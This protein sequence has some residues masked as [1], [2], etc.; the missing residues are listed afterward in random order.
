MKPKWLF[1]QNRIFIPKKYKSLCLV[2]IF[3]HIQ[4]FPQKWSKY[5]RLKNFFLAKLDICAILRNY[6]GLCGA[7]IISS[8][9]RLCGSEHVHATGGCPTC[10]TMWKE[11]TA[12]GP[13]QARAVKKGIVEAAWRVRPPR[14]SGGNVGPRGLWA[15]RWP[16]GNA[17]VAAAPPPP[18]GATPTHWFT[19]C[20]IRRR[21]QGGGFYRSNSFFRKIWT[22]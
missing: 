20:G 1:L 21:S 18:K 13:K 6:Q 8:G 19:R 22:G 4:Y 5:K 2:W 7:H 17:A 9:H 16:Q 15:C 14:G 11:K 3:E 12:G 10:L